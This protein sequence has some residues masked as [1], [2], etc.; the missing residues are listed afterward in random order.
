MSI[1]FT[2]KPSTIDPCAPLIYR[3]SIP[4]LD[5]VYHG[6]SKNG[7]KRPRRDY[8]RNVQRMLQGMPKRITPG[9]QHYRAIHHAMFAAVQGGH[10]IHLELVENCTAET[11]RQR[12]Q[13]WIARADRKWQGGGA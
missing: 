3:I 4:A 11:L 12:E 13:W 6:L 2:E 1:N 8:V 10:E 9:Q 7:A 5:V